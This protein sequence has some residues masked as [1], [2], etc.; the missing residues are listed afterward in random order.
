LGLA[1]VA[2]I[3]ANNNGAL[4]IQSWPSCGTVFEIWW[5]LEPGG[6]RDPAVGSDAPLRAGPGL[7][8]KAVLVV[9]D[10]PAVVDTLAEMLEQLGVEVGPCLDPADAIAV[11]RDD[12]TG[13]DLVITDY[14]MPGMNG[15]QLAKTL[16]KYR[17]DLPVLLLTALPRVHQLH[18]GPD[19]VFDGV[20]G[21]PTSAAR[22]AS[23]AA[24]A[25]AAARERSNAC[26]S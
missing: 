11:I 15:A 20:L 26:V 18:Q 14:D 16:R 22:L 6:V 2:G 9:D 4:A 8:G 1:V 17:K 13:W 23:S 25:M 5:P 10:N 12:P 19:G 21:K 24:A 3:I 7:L